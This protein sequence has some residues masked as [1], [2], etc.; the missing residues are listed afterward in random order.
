VPNTFFFDK[1]GG[2]DRIS[3]FNAAEGDRIEFAAKIGARNMSVTDFIAA[4]AKVEGDH[5]V[6]HMPLGDTLQIDHDTDISGQAGFID[7]F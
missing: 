7:L 4:Y 1:L 5:I 3:D 2:H 6:F